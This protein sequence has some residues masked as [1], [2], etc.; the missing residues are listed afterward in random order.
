M[1]ARVPG[2]FSKLL[3]I[4]YTSNIAILEYVSEIFL[5]YCLDIC[6]SVY[7]RISLD[8]KYFWLIL[9]VEFGEIFGIL[10][11]YC[12]NQKGKKLS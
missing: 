7:Q 1:P 10:T 5:D 11:I 8:C 6:L 2:L 9:H 4:P 12:F 3:P